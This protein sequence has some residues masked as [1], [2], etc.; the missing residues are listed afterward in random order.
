[1]F[2]SMHSNKSIIEFSSPFQ[3]NTGQ[4]ACSIPK[5]SMI[6]TSINEAKNMID[7]MKWKK[8]MPKKVVKM[9]FLPFDFLIVL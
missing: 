1:M 6:G 8:D 4:R 3:R 2:V 9:L 5:L 7:F